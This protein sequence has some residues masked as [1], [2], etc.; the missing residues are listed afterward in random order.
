MEHVPDPWTVCSEIFRVLKPGGLYLGS[1]AFLQ[2]LHERSHY[3]MTHLGI[4]RMLVKSSFVVEKIIPFEVSGFE[5]LARSLFVVKQPVS[6]LVA[7]Q[8]KCI[9]FLRKVGAKLARKIYSKDTMKLR[10]ISQFAAEERMRFASG[11]IYV[12]R[13]PNNL[14]SIK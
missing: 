8:F 11:F 9:M 1:T 5:A 2:A 7:L 3:H 4:E 14:Q 13:K 12:A 10:R 6:C